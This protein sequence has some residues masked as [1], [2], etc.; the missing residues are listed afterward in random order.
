M[1]GIYIGAKI[2]KAFPESESAF[3]RNVKQRTGSNIGN[4]PGYRVIYPDGYISWSP[5]DT[6]EQAYRKV[7]AEET[8]LV[9]EGTENGDR[10]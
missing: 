5:K 1:E 3:M 8:K 9:T 7:S 4:R 10:S 2:I 6:F